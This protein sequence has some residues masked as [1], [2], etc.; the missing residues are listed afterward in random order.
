MSLAAGLM[1]AQIIWAQAPDA[2]ALQ[3]HLQREVDQNHLSQVP[4]PRVKAA[5]TPPKPEARKE[6]VEKKKCVVFGATLIN[7]GQIAQTLASFEN[8]E[9][10]FDNFI[11]R[12]PPI[13][14][15][16]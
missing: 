3:Q 2:G 7:S 9:P 16:F 14:G 8:H 1:H 10:S 13:N 15:G 12:L 5:P 6:T 4:E 11:F